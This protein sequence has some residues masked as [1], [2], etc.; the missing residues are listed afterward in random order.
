MM[1]S[2]GWKI[3]P[4]AGGFLA[5]YDNCFSHARPHH[6]TIANTYFIQ[7]I[8]PNLTILGS[9]TS[10]SLSQHKGLRCL[11][12]TGPPLQ[13]GVSSCPPSC[14]QVRPCIFVP[15]TGTACAGACAPCWRTSRG[16]RG[17]AKSGGERARQTPSSSQNRVTWFQSPFMI[18]RK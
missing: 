3:R 9:S 8:A 7:N 1:G 16:C 18:R 6:K 5:N 12:H 15:S 13:C 4:Q 2:S 11:E 10:S 17:S 14:A